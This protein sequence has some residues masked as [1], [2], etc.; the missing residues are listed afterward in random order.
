V[1]HDSLASI[2]RNLERRHQRLQEIPTLALHDAVTRY[3]RF[4]EGN[5][6]L[7]GIVADLMRRT[8]E[9]I[10][11]GQ[12]VVRNK[13]PRWAK[14]D[15]SNAALSFAVLFACG[16][17]DDRNIETEI[18]NT[19]E[20]NMA[21]LDPPA[22]AFKARFLPPVY[23]YLVEHLD[24][25]RALLALLRRYKH[26]CE[27]FR[28]EALLALWQKDKAK[29]ERALAE[30]L[31]EYLHDQGLEFAIEPSSAS[32]K[33]D[34]ISAQV[35]DERLIADAKVFKDGTGKSYLASGFHQIYQYTLDYNQPFGYLVIFK[36]CED[37]LKFPMADHEQSI[38]FLV[39]NNKTLFFV[40]IDICQHE[41]TASKR[42]VLKTIEITEA[43]L[44][45]TA[46]SDQG[47]MP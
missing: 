46:A 3:V 42:G 20:T 37:D 35:G 43:D 36:T 38:P 1:N 2:E 18:G 11:V 45:Q 5:P 30:D 31:Y 33:P 26:R 15:E 21:S 22:A 32:G 6:L 7:C 41:A 23:D 9:A 47:Q 34:L 28:R 39:H 4:I 17:S 25:Q 27:W 19:Y 29:G 10:T 16:K 40:V 8:P 12:D 14:T 44:I 13:E 24:D